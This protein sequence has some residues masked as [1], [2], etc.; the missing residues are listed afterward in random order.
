MAWKSPATTKDADMLRVW[1]QRS[2]VAAF[3]VLVVCSLLIGR[4]ADASDELV[5]ATSKSGWL[6]WIAEARGLFEKH[7]VNVSVELTDSGVTAGEGLID[8]RY[9]MATMSEFAFVSRSFA[10]PDLRVFGTVAAIYNVRL[11]GRPDSGFASISDL[12]GKTIGLRSGAIGEFFLGKV[13]ELNGMSLDDVAIKDVQ[14]PDLPRSLKDGDVDAIVSW[15]PYATEAME[16][17]GNGALFEEVQAGQPY[18]FALV[19]SQGTLNKHPQ[20]AE[21]L[22]KALLEA[23]DWA[24]ANQS[25]AKRVLVDVLG[26]SAENLDRY[27]GDH[28][29][30]VAVAQDMLFLMEQEAR[31]RIQRGL[32]D[33]EMPNFLERIDPNPLKRVAPHLVS[34]ID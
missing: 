8:G 6:L 17:V 9:D 18:Y 10:N 16:A 5:V 34:I 22:L 1:L 21:G 3:I 24:M 14:V 13:I 7:E 15:E 33:G 25:E 27:W 11:V 29:M 30:E 2:R 31:W 26:L 23:S 19:A 4:T 32:S 28:V 20:A 12:P